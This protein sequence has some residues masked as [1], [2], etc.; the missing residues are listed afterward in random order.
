M[1]H[2]PRADWFL[3]DPE[4]DDAPV[5]LFCFPHAGGGPRQ[6]L[7]WQA[8]LG[9]GVQLHALV[10][11]GRG[12]RA[13]QPAPATVAAFAA[14]AA[15]AVEELADRPAILVGHSF[16]AVAAF[17]VARTLRH[18]TAISDLVASGCAA[19]RRLPSERVVAASQLEG[20]AFAEA[21][22]FFGGL[23]PELVA[24]EELHDLVL[25]TLQADFAL[26]AGYRYRPAEPLEIRVHLV[27][28]RDDQHVRGDALEGWAEECTTA[29]TVTAMAGGHFYF[30]P[31]PSALLAVLGELVEQ[32]QHL[33]VI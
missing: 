33:E 4:L 21:V 31:D 10:A 14:G 1:N 9:P 32:H 13:G 23:P 20:R 24:A 19:P 15:A 17:E 25:P 22:G 2:S 29:P 5:R 8:A 3:A 16:G 27:N 6:F 7:S 28:G 12:H 11:P 18:V 30:D 26:V